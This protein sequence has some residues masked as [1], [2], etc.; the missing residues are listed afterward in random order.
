MTEERNRRETSA[1]RIG[2]KKLSS[3]M[4]DALCT[5]PVSMCPSSKVGS[6]QSDIFNSTGKWICLQRADKYWKHRADNRKQKPEVFVF[7]K[8][9]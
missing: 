9:S 3:A 7:Y 4:M 6:K 8:R 5:P 1:L 2:E